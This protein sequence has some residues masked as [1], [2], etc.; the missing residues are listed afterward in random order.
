MTRFGVRLPPRLSVLFCCTAARVVA[1][2]GCDRVAL[3][4]AG[5]LDA[6]L[7]LASYSYATALRGTVAAGSKT[8]AAL[9]AG[10][11]HDSE[12]DVRTVDLG[13]G[14]GRIVRPGR[15]RRSRFCVATDLAFTWGHF[16]PRSPEM[17][18]RLM[19]WGLSLG[20]SRPLVERDAWR[21]HAYEIVQHQQ[22]RYVA[23][24]SA[25]QKQAGVASRNWLDRYWILGVGVMTEFRQ[26]FFARVLGSVPM[27]LVP[28]GPPSDPAKPDDVVVPFGREE[29]ELAF[30]LTL[31]FLISTVH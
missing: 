28:P 23:I 9:T 14:L 4:E 2:Q 21:V 22:L 6:A 19:D 8:F 17:A 3:P 15:L 16:E 31:G 10:S 20:H 12:L 30:T 26:R 1:A 7:S 27:G 25:A 29:H 24:P 18:H 5:S 11:S 13:I